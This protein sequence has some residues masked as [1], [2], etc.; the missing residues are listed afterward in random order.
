MSLETTLRLPWGC[1][2]VSTA[3]GQGRVIC[4]FVQPPAEFIRV[5]I[6]HLDRPGIVVVSD[7]LPTDDPEPGPGGPVRSPHSFM[8]LPPT[9]HESLSSTIRGIS[10]C[11]PKTW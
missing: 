10:A 11:Q 1:C 2:F 6:I 4:F 3:D 9:Q 8:S 7:V 5:A